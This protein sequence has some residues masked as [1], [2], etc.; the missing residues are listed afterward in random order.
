M[1]GIPGHEGGCERGGRE[2]EVFTR[3]RG[4]RRADNAGAYLIFTS[5]FWPQGPPISLQLRLFLIHPLS[6]AFAFIVENGI[7]A[8]RYRRR[9]YRSLCHSD[10]CRH[11]LRE[12]LR[13]HRSAHKGRRVFADG[14]PVSKTDKRSRKDLRIALRTKMVN[15]RLHVPWPS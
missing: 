5:K 8:K 10:R 2:Q 6:S 13:V 14:V 12:L 1:I 15:A 3:K 9:T 11:Q 7:S 4:V